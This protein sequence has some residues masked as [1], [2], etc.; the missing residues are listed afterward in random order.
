MRTAFCNT[1]YKKAKNNKAILLITG[2]LGFSVFEDYIKDYPNQ[3]LNAGVSEQ[4]LTGVASGMALEGKIP[5]IYSIIPFITMRN[6]EQIR[7]DVCY[8]NANVKIVGVGTGFMY[9]PYGRT[10]HGLEDIGIMRTLPNLT[11]FSPADIFE[12]DRVVNLSLKLKNPCYIRLGRAEKNIHSVKQSFKVGEGIVVKKGSDIC[13]I[14]T[15]TMVATAIETAAILEKSKISSTLISMPS[16]KPIDKELIIQ[17][18]KNH[19]AI[20]TIEDH[21]IVG[22]L[23]SIV[24]EIIAEQNVKVSFLRI[25]VPDTITHFVGNREFMNDIH[26]LSVKKISEKI[27][28][29][30]A[31]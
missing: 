18:L 12:T 25:G 29:I 20:F 19:K 13:I 7:N 4:N 10:H 14:S 15:G 3:Y 27:L 5:F 31:A 28:R 6:F 16:L 24:S 21:S 22:G 8:Q 2:D 11:I 17:S 30:Y 26:G 1:L 23:G 9:G